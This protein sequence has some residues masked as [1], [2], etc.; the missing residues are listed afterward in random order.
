VLAR[1]LA[2]ARGPVELAEAEVAV[3]DEGAPAF[4][5]DA[6]NAVDVAENP[7]CL[8]RVPALREQAAQAR[9]GSKLRGAITAATGQLDCAP[10]TGL[11]L[12]RTG[13]PLAQEQL[14]SAAMDLGP[15]GNSASCSR[16]IPRCT[17][18]SVSSAP[19]WSSTKGTSFPMTEAVCSNCLSA[20]ASR[21]SRAARIT[22]TVPGDLDRL[23]R[24][25]QA[26]GAVLPGERPRLH[27]RA[28]ALLDDER[29][30]AFDQQALEEFQR[31]VVAQEGGGG[32][33]VLSGGR[34]SSRSWL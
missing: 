28:D 19:A 27:E 26:M 34:A 12:G 1:L 14:S 10:E 6:D 18:S 31:R 20:A 16:A 32:S 9:R 8:L 7:P 11:R 4:H 21:S 22:W 23:D 13:M 25:G 17:A 33:P 29:V 30:S 2:L 15:Y 24:P 3:G 5:L